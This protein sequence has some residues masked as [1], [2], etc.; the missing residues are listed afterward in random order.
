MGDVWFGFPINQRRSVAILNT[1]A[2]GF[3][4]DYIVWLAPKDVGGMPPYLISYVMDGGYREVITLSFEEL[5][6]AREADKDLIVY[7]WRRIQES[8]V[9]AP[10]AP[11]YI[12]KRAE[13]LHRFRDSL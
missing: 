8:G 11:E 12:R 1:L 2:D 5:Q 13:T 10:P 4:E 7:A 6:A 3:G 9:F